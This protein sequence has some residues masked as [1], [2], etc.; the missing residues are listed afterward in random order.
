MAIGLVVFLIAIIGLCGVIRDSGCLL[1]LFS[2]LL[3]IVLIGEFV[4]SG[5]VYHMSGNIKKYVL[6]QMNYTISVYNTTDHEASTLAW[7]VLQTDIECCGIY[8]PKDWKPITHNDELPKSCCY[9]IPVG[10][11]CTL[12]YSWNNGCYESLESNIQDNSQLLI[13]TAIGFAFIQLFAVF[14]ACCRKCSIHEEYE[15][16]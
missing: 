8:G 12:E 5:V 9:A 14:L 13:W 11:I 16:V 3:T 7:N 2:I 10:G 1:T 15:T 6:D 4:L